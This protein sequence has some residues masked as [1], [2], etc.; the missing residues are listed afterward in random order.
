MRIIAVT[1][2]KGGVGKTTSVVN[3]GAG[4]HRLNHKVLVVDMDPQAHLSYSLGI[5]VDDLDRSVFEVLKG[6]VAVNEILADR[7][8]L[9]ILPAHIDLAAADRELASKT[10]H[11]MFLKEALAG[12]SGY[13]YIL[14][15]CP[16]NLGLLTLNALMAA[17]EVFVPMQAE[18]LSIKGLNNLLKMLTQL[19][20]RE[21]PTLEL[22]GIILTLFDRRLRLHREVVEKLR[23]YFGSKLF[24]TFIRRNISLA[25]AASFGESIYE[26]APRSHGAEDYTALCHQITK[27]TQND[28]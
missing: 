2:Q 23:H 17:Q 3:I 11:E 26:Y 15:D 24:P 21:N 19:K 12:A 28:G 1:N 10:G 20:Q 18:F 14:I 9:H 8:G 22:T 27:M 16:P 13:D 4:L 25:E 5:P 6:E 7:D